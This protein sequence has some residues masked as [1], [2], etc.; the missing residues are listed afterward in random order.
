MVTSPPL[1]EPLLN[2]AIAKKK[3]TGSTVERVSKKT[4]EHLS[5]KDE[6]SRVF[7]KGL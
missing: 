1:V 6:L 5:V 2:R 4:K 7:E 3:S